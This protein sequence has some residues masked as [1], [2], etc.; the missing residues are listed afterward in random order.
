VR[1]DAGILRFQDDKMIFRTDQ[2][3]EIRVVETAQLPDHSDPSVTSLLG[4]RVTI[5]WTEVPE[6][7]NSPRVMAHEVI[8]HRD[9]AERAF[10]F[11]KRLREGRRWI[12]GRA[13]KMS[14]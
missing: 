4:Q 13:L 11:L 10:K 3:E 9:I 8:R 5:P 12:I 2:S 7:D 1:K 6:T 14:F